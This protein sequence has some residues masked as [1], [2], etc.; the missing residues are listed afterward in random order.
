MGK[1]QAIR[2]MHDVLPEQSQLWQFLEDQVRSICDGFGYQEIRT[3]VVESTALFKRAIGEVTDIVEKEMYTFDD[4]NGDSLTLRPEGTAG[5][6]RACIENGLLH[7]QTQRLW[8]RGA[9]FRHERPQKGRYRQFH[10]IGVEAFGMEGPDIDLE[11]I[12][13]TASLWQALGIDGLELQINSLGTSE[14]RA[15]Y[16]EELVK[17]LRQ[18]EEKLDDDSKRRL[19]TNPLR[20]LDSKNPDVQAIVADAPTLMEYLGEESRTHFEIL[21]NGLKAAGIEY[22][23]NQRLVRGLDYYSLSVFEWVTNKLG[24]QGTV[25]AGGRY[26]GLIEQLGGRASK[27][28]G[29]AMGIE[30]LVALLEEYHM[31]ELRQTADIYIISAD[32]ARIHAQAVAQRL[33]VEIEGLRVISHCGTGGFKAQFKKADRSGAQIALVLGEDE[34][35][36]GV[37]GIKPLRGDGEQQQVAIA[38][39]PDKLQEWIQ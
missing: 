15:A 23:I 17:F 35:A 16:R 11:I 29:F 1:I 24:A 25:C 13:M 30:R 20:V 39:L 7:N 32:E 38:D 21:C 22:V 34:L 12:L 9:M 19:E 28:V 18:H 27:A 31:P 26:D 14:E 8:Y 33:R 3:P 6:V 5:C 4:R 2:G 37:I 36:Q 10:Q